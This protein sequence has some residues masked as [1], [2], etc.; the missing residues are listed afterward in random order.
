[1]FLIS[2]S[3]M[4]GLVGTF[5]PSSST[6]SALSPD[7]IATDMFFTLSGLVSKEWRLS[8]GNCDGS[9]EEGEGERVM[10]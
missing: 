1:M 4:G 3:G 8:L 2:L 5:S 6:L 7:F 10:G 9:T